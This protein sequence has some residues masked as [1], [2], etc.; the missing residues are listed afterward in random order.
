MRIRIASAFLLGVVVLVGA[1]LAIGL[2]PQVESQ[3]STQEAVEGACSRMAK[4]DSY[5]MHTVIKEAVDGALRNDTITKKA[6]ISGEDYHSSYTLES[7]GATDEAIRV[8]GVGYYRTTPGNI[9][10]QVINP[11][12]DTTAHLSALGDSPICPDLSKVTWDSEEDLNGVKVQHYVSGDIS[13]EEANKLEDVA[14]DFRGEKQA[15]RHDY[16]V[17]SEGQLVQHRMEAHTLAHYDSGRHIYTATVLST[18][19]E[20]GEPIV[21]TAPA[22]P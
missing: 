10:W 18:F 16:W 9:G 8:G 22:V 12:A 14:G 1:Y 3:A 17:D 13:G 5:V 21:I 15:T 11:L 6:S 7:T 20:V 4:V 19:S 2:P